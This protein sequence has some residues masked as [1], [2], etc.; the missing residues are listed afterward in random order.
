MQP[1]WKVRSGAFAG[2]RGE[3]RLYNAQGANVGYFKDDVAYSTNGQY[4]GEIRRDDWIGKRTGIA[5]AVAGVRSPCT[6]ITLCQHVGRVGLAVG[7]WADP[8]F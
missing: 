2:Y 6:G 7:G 1:L 3:D 5:H 4:I 8:D